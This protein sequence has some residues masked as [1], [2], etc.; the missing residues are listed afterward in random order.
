MSERAK[1]LQLLRVRAARQQERV[2][3][4]PVAAGATDHLHV[5]LQRLRIVVERDE[6]DVGLVDPHAERRRRDHRLHVPAD[7]GLLRGRA[8]QRLEPG[9]VVDRGEVV[10][11][12]RPR[13]GLAAAPRARVDDRRGPVQL[14]QPPH[15]RA[16]AVLLAVDELDV[17][18]QVVAHDARAHDLRLA[19]ERVCDLPL[20]RRRRSGGHPEDG[21]PAERV[22]G[23]ADEE[24]VGPEVVS[25]HAHA[26]HLVDHDEPDVDGAERVE[27]APLAQPLGCG[28]QEAIA[29]FGD[30]AQPPRRL[31]GLE[32][33]VDQRRLGGHLGRQLVHLVLHQRDQRREDE[34]R[35]GAEH[36]RELVGERLAGAGRHQRERVAAL[37]CRLD[38]LLLAGAEGGEAEQTRQRGRQRAHPNECTVTHRNASDT[39][40]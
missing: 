28:V 10:V 22:E 26:V 5:A 25:P 2:G 39:D 29:A 27:E 35:G 4:A 30:A 19:S 13:Q 8:L 1:R 33:G 32:R 11:A 18:A 7:E 34:R 15:E 36:R 23:A 24:V 40:V 14:L 17:V 37:H 38:D 9:V 3:R 31:V 6:A 20:G 21:R 12:E 16:Q